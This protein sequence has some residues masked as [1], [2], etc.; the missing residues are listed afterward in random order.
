MNA[1]TAS[2]I[3]HDPAKAI[4]TLAHGFDDE[5]RVRILLALH[6]GRALSA[7]HLAIEAGVAPSTASAHLKQLLDAGLIR[8]V[9]PPPN[10]GKHRSFT[11]ASPEV[12]AL[13]ESFAAMTPTLTTRSLQPGTPEARMRTAR[14]CYD[15]LAGRL[16]VGLLDAMLSAGILTPCDAGFSLTTPGE[17]ALSRFG[18]DIPG[19]RSSATRRPIIRVCTDW[20]EQRPHLSGSLGKALLDQVVVRGWVVRSL[21]DRTLTITEDGERGFRSWFGF[22]IAAE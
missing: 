20:S 13:C 8:L 15:H 18:I 9:P 21:G 3:A 17:D 10:H 2:T 11:L 14:S 12:A 7:T 6:D 22:D 4:A 19:L 5:R 1:E 16:A